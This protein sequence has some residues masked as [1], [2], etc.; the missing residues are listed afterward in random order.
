[1][2]A[3]R[4]VV[5]KGIRIQSNS[6]DYYRSIGSH[7]GTKQTS[8]G[9]RGTTSHKPLQEESHSTVVTPSRSM[10]LVLGVK[11]VEF[12]FLQRPVAEVKTTSHK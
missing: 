7:S 11:A 9:Q 6:L 5:I 8:S 1:M 2:R 3:N 4:P 10:E 12:F